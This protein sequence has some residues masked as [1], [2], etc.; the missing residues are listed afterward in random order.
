MIRY[1]DSQTELTVDMI[2][3]RVSDLDIFLRYCPGFRKVGVK[4]HSPFRKDPSPSAVVSQSIRFPGRLHFTDFGMREHSYDSIHFVQ[5]ITGSSFTEAL[6]MIDRDMMLGLL[7]GSLAPEVIPPG[8]TM[9][10]RSQIQVRIRPFERR[11]R[12]YWDQYLLSESDLRRFGVHPISHFW[13][14]AIRHDAEKLAYVYSGTSP[15]LKLYSPMSKDVKW[16]SNTTA[17]DIHGWRQL[18]RNGPLMAITSSLKDAMC[19]WA[20]GVPAIAMQT[21]AIIPSIPVIG[22]LRRRFKDIIV[23]YDND[24]YSKDN[25]GQM[26]A[27]TLCMEHYLLNVCLPDGPYKDVAELLEAEG[28]IIT[29]RIILDE[30]RKKKEEEQVRQQAE[31]GLPF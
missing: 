11:D 16:L 14:N 26:Y 18:P 5:A 20:I 28:P 8:Q 10:K 30:Y 19:L 29:R 15:R 7:G 3:S 4:F 22:H 21:E 1:R 13:L 6:R 27:R 2:R 9:R 23:V 17:A 24:L 31:E 12:W 25:P